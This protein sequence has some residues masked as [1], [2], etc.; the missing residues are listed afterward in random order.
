MKENSIKSLEGLGKTAYRSG[1]LP[2]FL[3]IL[4]SFI[5]VINSNP[6]DILIGL[7][8]FVVGYSFVNIGRKIRS[9]LM[10]EKKH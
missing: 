7:F 10:S 4:I 6:K 3:G 8:V 5:G 1:V 2:I 9:I